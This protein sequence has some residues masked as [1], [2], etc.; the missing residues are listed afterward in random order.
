M[1]IIE[2]L[3]NHET[4]SVTRNDSSPQQRW[5]LGRDLLGG[6]YFSLVGHTL[7]NEPSL[8]MAPTKL[9]YTLL[10]DQVRQQPDFP[11]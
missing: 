4:T 3:Q 2:L 8:H 5:P 11:L 1:Q 10:G 9:K 6:A 7:R